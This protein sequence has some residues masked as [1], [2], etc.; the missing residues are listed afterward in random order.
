M[1]TIAPPSPP[2]ERQAIFNSLAG[3]KILVTGGTGFI[4]RHLV[5]AFIRE[6]IEP[7]LLT[8]SPHRVE[9]LFGSE[10]PLLVADLARPEHIPVNHPH[11]Y[12]LVI[13]CAAWQTGG[14]RSEALKVNASGSEALVKLA[15][16]GGAV[17]FIYLS[18]IAVYGRVGNEDVTEDRPLVLYGDPY[19]DSKILGE[20][21]V[22]LTCDKNNL[23][24]TILRPGMVYGP[25]SETWGSRLLANARSG[26]LPMIDEGRGLAAPIYID[27]LIRLIGKVAVNQE[28]YGVIL[29][30][31]GDP[32]T[33]SD[34]FGGFMA[35]VGSNKALRL[36]LPL[37][38]IGA[39]LL[40][41]FSLDRDLPYAID[42]LS[43]KGRI[44]NQR[45]KKLGWEPLIG[46]EE[47]L[48]RTSTAFRAEG[49]L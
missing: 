18:S 41:P 38:Q 10:I 45:A 24:F 25:G 31:T 6:G 28:A 44:V 19:G 2:P 32:V 29:N 46:L 11:Q 1:K 8:R 49:L 4:G 14:K 33:F 23:P 27:D 26:R 7:T 39:F 15:A 37:I 35:M 22:R 42:L 21:V 48:S 20:T 5:S 9:E 43:R 16:K 40:N 30:A 34:F 47:G 36:P 12:D 13:H 3:K 17:Q